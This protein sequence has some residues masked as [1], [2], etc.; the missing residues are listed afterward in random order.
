M[1][2]L[3]VRI[4]SEKKRLVCGLYFIPLPKSR[5]ANRKETNT[6]ALLQLSQVVSH[7][8]SSAFHFHIVHLWQRS[9]TATSNKWC[10]LTCGPTE[11]KVIAV[12]TVGFILRPDFSRLDAMLSPFCGKVAVYF[13]VT[14][15]SIWIDKWARSTDARVSL[16]ES[17]SYLWIKSLLTLHIAII[18]VIAVSS[19]TSQTFIKWIK[20]WLYFAFSVPEP[21]E[22]KW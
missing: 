4:L 2:L 11:K 22:T 12:S 5:D 15:C 20:T 8:L 21:E 6:N 18:I 14:T 10:L 16:M 19:E 1:C 13:D 7:T 3:V 9:A 17:L